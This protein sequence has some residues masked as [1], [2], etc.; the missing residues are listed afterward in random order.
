[1]RGP[2]QPA[3]PESNTA[4]SMGTSVPQTIRL[5]HCG[6]IST[7]HPCRREGGFLGALRRRGYVAFGRVDRPKLGKMSAA[8]TDS[9]RAI[10]QP[11]KTYRLDG[12]ALAFGNMDW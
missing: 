5:V 3:Q 2:C 10:D 9:A 8:E 11:V 6:D 4:Q 12:R 1:M 7:G